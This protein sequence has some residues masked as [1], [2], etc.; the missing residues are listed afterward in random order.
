MKRFNELSPA[1]KIL[2]GL[3]VALGIFVAIEALVL[4]LFWV[5][6]GGELFL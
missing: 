1:G 3:L 4:F 6:L 2:R 5:M